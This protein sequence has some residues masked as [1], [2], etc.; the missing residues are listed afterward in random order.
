MHFKIKK[1]NI[2]KLIWLLVFKIAR[3]LDNIY[4]FIVH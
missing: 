2:K 3:K 1:I 4:N